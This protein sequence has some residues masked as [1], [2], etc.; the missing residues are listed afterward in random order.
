MPYRL[1]AGPLLRLSA[2]AGAATPAS[3]AA[4]ASAGPALQEERRRFL[5]LYEIVASEGCDRPPPA[6]R[7]VNATPLRP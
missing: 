6:N 5:V 7:G 2:A 1:V 3:G 4:A